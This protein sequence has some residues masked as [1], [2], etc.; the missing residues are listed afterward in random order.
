MADSQDSVTPT[1]GSNQFDTRVLNLYAGIGGNRKLWENVE[2][3]AVENEQYIADAYKQLFPDDTVIVADAHQYL[4]D[5]HTEFDF[6]WSSPPCP[7]HSK[8]NTTL[9]A[10][11]Y[12]RYPDMTLYQ[13]ILFLKH[14]YKGQWVV[15]NV[16]SYY[17]PLILP[18]R[19]ARH[20]FWSNFHISKYNGR[21]TKIEYTEPEELAA[22]L[23]IDASL[24]GDRLLRRKVLRNSVQP[25]LGLH[26]LNAAQG[27]HGHSEG[28]ELVALDLELL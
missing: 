9:Y 27:T 28:I 5:H 19:V 4:L 24:I 22:M 16:E 3:T 26:V 2:V 23:N 11:G 6:I 1:A 13:E 25:E 17:S 15:E 14:F 20:Y 21:T 10:Q 12:I 7:T 8:F 18:Q